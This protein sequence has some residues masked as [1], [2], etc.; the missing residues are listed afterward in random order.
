MEDNSGYAMTCPGCGYDEQKCWQAKPYGWRCTIC[1][2]FYVENYSKINE[3]DVL[4]AI[5]NASSEP[6]Y[7]QKKGGG[8][9][10]S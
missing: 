1:G 7:K 2:W 6:Y 10:I 4:E 3:P 8:R 9:A 5:E